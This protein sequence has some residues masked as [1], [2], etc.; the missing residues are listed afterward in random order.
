MAGLDH[1]WKRINKLP[2]KPRSVSIQRGIGDQGERLALTYLTQHKL[3]LVECNYRCVFGEI[4]LIM[5]DRDCLVFVEVKQRKS[6]HY[7]SP[8][9]M[10]SVK[11]QQKLRRTAEHYISQRKLSSHQ[12]LRFDAVGIIAGTTIESINWVQNAF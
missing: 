3:T 12:A 4:D 7:G 6:S 8:L 10:I 11:K 2:G 5:R 9:E 1:W